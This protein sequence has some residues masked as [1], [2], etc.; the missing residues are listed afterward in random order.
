[1]FFLSAIGTLEQKQQN[2]L[3][4]LAGYLFYGSWDWRFLPVLFLSTGFDF[5]LFRFLDR[6]RSAST[7]LWA[8][9]ISIVLNLGVLSLFKYYDFFSN[10]LVRTLGSFDIV[11]TAPKLGLALPVGISFYTLQKLGYGFDAYFNRY[12]P[13]RQFI[14]FALYVCFFPLV[15]S[16]PIERS[17]RLMPQ[18]V[19][20]RVCND[21]DFSEGIYHVA[22]GLFKKT[23]LADN[24]APMVNYIFSKDP[25]TLSGPECL[26]GMYSIYFSNILRFFR[27]FPPGSR[28]GK[29]VGF[30]RNVELQNAIFFKDTQRVLEALAHK[31]FVMDP[32][33]PLHPSGWKPPW[34]NRTMFN[35]VVT[36]LV[37]G[38][39]HGAAWTFIV[40]G[41]FHGLLLMSID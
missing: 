23:V 39:W 35:L 41:M 5:F 36:M 3:L 17:N 40:W 20:S 38:L 11:V 26:I 30:R 28:H 2:R 8:I 7:R 13:P 33:L 27:L 4:L 1:M 25:L 12:S 29:T 10:E 24:L 19:G 22:M 14:D 16:G 37:V 9:S 32:G 15:L 31:P 21:N 18:I 34:G 6:D